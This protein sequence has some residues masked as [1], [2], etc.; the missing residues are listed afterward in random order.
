MASAYRIARLRSGFVASV[1]F[2]L[3]EF[4]FCG[5][6]SALVLGGLGDGGD[7]RVV[8]EVFAQGAAQDT[9][10]RAVDDADAG[11]A[12]EERSVYEALYFGLGLVGGAADY[13]DL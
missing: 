13:V 8:A 3:A 6:L 11:Q 10:A 7:V 4:Y 12:G 1:R 2:L 9:H 5:A